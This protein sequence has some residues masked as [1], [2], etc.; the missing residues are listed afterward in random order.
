MLLADSMN[1]FINAWVGCQND[2]I[3]H[4]TICDPNRKKY[5]VITTDSVIC[6][7][8]LCGGKKKCSRSADLLGIMAFTVHSDKA[9]H[10]VDVICCDQWR[11]LYRISTQRCLWDMN[12]CQTALSSIRVPPL[13]Q[14]FAFTTHLL[15]YQI[16]L[17]Q[18][19][20]IRKKTPLSRLIFQL[21][22]AK[23]CFDLS[24]LKLKFNSNIHL[25]NELSASC[26]LS[27]IIS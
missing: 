23:R 25:W 19:A 11:L 22:V 2:V 14:T 4:L 20:L 15:V 16:V 18:S 10:S 24:P 6:S 8:A 5:D 17:L 27:I 12:P 21:K 3:W 9:S 26:I 1:R 13:K 7:V